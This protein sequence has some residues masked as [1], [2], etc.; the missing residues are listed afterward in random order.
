MALAESPQSKKRAPSEIRRKEKKCPGCGL[1][2]PIEEF[3]TIYGVENPQGKYCQRCFANH[4]REHAMSLMEGRD[5]CLYCGTRIEKAYDWTPEGNSA[6]TYLHLDH[7]DPLLRGGKDSDNNT[8]YC[9]VACNLKKGDKLFTDWLA[10][11][12]PE[13]REISR[14]IYIEKHHREPE[15]FNPSSNKV[16]ITIDFG[17]VLNKLLQSNSTDPKN[18]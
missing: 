9:C 18:R 7:M 3:V 4:E 16:V 17:D 12:T 15:A 5:F 6:R 11:L 2:K 10:E 1:V 13:Y 8:V 14:N